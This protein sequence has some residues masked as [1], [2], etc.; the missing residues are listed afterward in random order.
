MEVNPPVET[1]AIREKFK[2]YLIPNGNIKGGRREIAPLII[3]DENRTVFTEEFAQAIESAQDGKELTRVLTLGFDPHQEPQLKEYLR[4]KLAQIRPDAKDST[5]DSNNPDYATP[6]QLL[7]EYDVVRRAFAEKLQPHPDLLQGLA[8]DYA[9]FFIPPRLKNLSR[10]EIIAE[11]LKSNQTAPTPPLSTET[12]AS[13][14]TDRSLVENSPQTS[15]E[16][17][18]QPNQAIVAELKF[19]GD[20][21]MGRRIMFG[22]QHVGQLL[23]SSDSIAVMI[24][25]NGLVMSTQQLDHI[26]EQQRYLSVFATDKDISLSKDITRIELVKRLKTAKALSD[27]ILG[28]NRRAEF[29]SN[30]PNE[31]T[32]AMERFDKA[33]ELIDEKLMAR[34]PKNVD[35]V[36]VKLASLHGGTKIT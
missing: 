1:T 2:T 32:K 15:L 3:N 30:D 25:D 35:Q 34:L 8:F 14:I 28:V 22:D 26:S 9:S 4:S 7:P 11:L 13:T 19:L 12:Q 27:D 18:E 31:Y 17:F 6:E 16:P 36:V 5:Q 21:K 20:E 10:S 24:L 23:P 33:L 29:S